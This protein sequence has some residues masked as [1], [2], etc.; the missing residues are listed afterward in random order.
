MDFNHVDHM[1]IEEVIKLL[2]D[3]HQKNRTGLSFKTGKNRQKDK[4]SWPLTSYHIFFS[5][6]FGE[7]GFIKFIESSYNDSRIDSL[8]RRTEKEA[9]IRE[10]QFVGDLCLLCL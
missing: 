2:I 5:A 9:A 10:Y 1:D 4:H 8:D 6:K 3:G 7:Y